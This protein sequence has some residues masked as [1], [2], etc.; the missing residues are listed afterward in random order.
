MGATVTVSKA[1]VVE[2]ELA[3]IRQL[4]PQLEVAVVTLNGVGCPELWI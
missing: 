2:F 3:A 4:A 1:G